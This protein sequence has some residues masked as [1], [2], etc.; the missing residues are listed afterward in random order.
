MNRRRFLMLAACAAL[1]H[2]AAALETW[3]GQAMG[4]DVSLR[5][6]GASPAQAR[7]FFD[8]ATRELAHVE[9]L[10]SL[11]RDSDLVRLNRDG[12]LRFP[13]EGMLELLALTERLHRATGGMFDPSVQP[14]WLARA[15]GRDEAAARRLTGWQEVEWS[16]QEIRLGRPGMGLTFNGLAQGWAADRL[17][18]AAARHDLTEVLIDCGELRALGPWEAGIA[19]AGGG[20]LR[21]ITLSDRALATS[22]PSGT[23]IGP[24][25][26]PHIIAPDGRMPLWR[27][28]SVSAPEAAVADGLSTALCLLGRD[29]AEAAAA[30]F[31]GAGIELLAVS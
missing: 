3:R 8:A 27:T 26:L 14:L 6:A 18:R 17:A 24:R 20:V 4:A 13:A 1:P 12:R 2:R 29:A 5:L 15:T 31:P 25:D 30:Q 11:H 19:D 9:S 21:R 16:A 23:R 28:V 22:S 7:G 10:F